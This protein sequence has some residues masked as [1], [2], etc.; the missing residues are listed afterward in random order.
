MLIQDVVKFN[1]GVR[2]HFVEAERN[3]FRVLIKD[4][5]ALQEFLQLLQELRNRP[6]WQGVLHLQFFPRWGQR[7]AHDEVPVVARFQFRNVKSVA[8]SL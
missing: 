4:E 1:D 5:L 7:I 8:G 3:R 6:M 2:Q